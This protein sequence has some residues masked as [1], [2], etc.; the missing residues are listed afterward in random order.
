[1]LQIL[2][3]R[4]TPASL[5]APFLY[6]HITAAASIGWLVWGHFPDALTWLGIGIISASGVINALAEW[7]RTK[8]PKT[9]NVI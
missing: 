7:R 2:A 5:L 1:M 4:T 8:V 9:P 3:Y 6:L